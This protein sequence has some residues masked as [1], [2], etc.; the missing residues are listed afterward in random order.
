MNILIGGIGRVEQAEGDEIERGRHAIIDGQ[1]APDH[2][3]D[4]FDDE[5]EAEGEQ[6]FRDVAEPMDAAQSEPLDQRADDAD[7]ERR[8]DQS[9]PEADVPR[10]LEAEI[11]AQHVEAGMGEIQ[12]A[13]HAEDQRQPARQHEQH[14]AVEHAVQRRKGDELEHGCSAV[15]G[16]RRAVSSRPAPRAC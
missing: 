8:D 16:S 15:G 7:E 1:L 11:S 13:H 5:G 12:H 9:R 4:F 6:Q 14:H 2:L 10:Y 3:H